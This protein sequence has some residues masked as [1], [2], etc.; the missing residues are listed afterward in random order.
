MASLEIKLPEG[1]R[2][3]FPNDNIA[4]LQCQTKIK[5]PEISNFAGCII[6]LL[7]VLSVHVFAF[8]TNASILP[9]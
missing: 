7:V 4:L 5:P 6:L 8:P 9:R 3:D 1:Y 2:V